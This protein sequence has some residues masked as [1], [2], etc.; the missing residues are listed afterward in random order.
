M[1]KTNNYEIIGNCAKFLIKT[2]NKEIPEK[3]IYF[4]I[5]LEDLELVNKYRWCARV[6][7]KDLIYITSTYGIQLHRLIMNCPKNKY[8]DHINLNTLDN[9]KNNLRVCTRYENAQNVKKRKNNSTGYRNVYFNKNE[10]KYYVILRANKKSYFGG[11]FSN[12]EEGIKEAIEKSIE[13]RRYICPFS[14]I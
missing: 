12:S 11:Y 13:M 2:T 10:N 7:R 6:V 8:V 9:R 5:D 3:K 4:L 14:T 1:G